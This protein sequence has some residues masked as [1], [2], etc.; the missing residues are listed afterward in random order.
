MVGF[1]TRR[2]TFQTVVHDGQA[3]PER[4][5]RLLQ[6]APRLVRFVTE[7]IRSTNGGQSPLLLGVI[8]DRAG[9]IQVVPL[10]LR[11]HGVGEMHQNR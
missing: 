6:T 9:E 8:F 7:Q 1:Y 10:V 4:V 2:P 11:K 5:L 3:L